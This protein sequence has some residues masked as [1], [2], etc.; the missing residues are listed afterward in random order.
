MHGDVAILS[1]E[2]DLSDYTG[3]LFAAV[4][5]HPELRAH[6]NEIRRRVHFISLRGTGMHLVEAEGGKATVTD[7]GE[8]LVG[9]LRPF[10]EL[11]WV[12]IETASRAN[13]SDEMNDGMARL[14]EACEIV[15]NALNVAVTVSHHT[16]KYALRNGDV[17]AT[18]S[19]GGTA[20]ADN[21]RATTVLALLDAESPAMLLPPG[22]SL[23]DMK[24]REIVLIDNVRSSYARKAPRVWVERKYLPE[25]LP[26]FAPLERTPA[27]DDKHAAELA[28]IDAK[29]LTFL[30]LRMGKDWHA[31]SAILRAWEPEHG[32]SRRVAEAAL[33]RLVRDHRVVKDA[34]PQYGSKGKLTMQYMIASAE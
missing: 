6:V 34:R 33:S 16:N 23:T 30:R 25:G 17:D 9:L 11:V 14:V 2:D 26:Y 13:A 15:A 22:Y 21:C 20:L 10:P 4:R 28:E 31:E 12:A 3:K 19:R 27:A 1:W 29:L 24:G 7:L 8:R 18:A 32:V 5:A